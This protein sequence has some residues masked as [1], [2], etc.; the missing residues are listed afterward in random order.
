MIGKF[1]RSRTCLLSVARFDELL[2]TLLGS[3][4]FV[5][6]VDGRPQSRLCVLKGS[7]NEDMA[8]LYQKIKSA[9]S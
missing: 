7:R 1:N 4:S 8:K 5:G 2:E 6:M 3:L 9:T